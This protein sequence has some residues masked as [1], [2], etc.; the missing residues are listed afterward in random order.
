MRPRPS[1]SCLWSASVAIS[2][3]CADGGT[4]VTGGPWE[5]D[6]VRVSARCTAPAFKVLYARWFKA[7][8]RVRVTIKVSGRL[9][10]RVRLWIETLKLVL[11]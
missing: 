7:R 10:A 4:R 2:R 9:G 1:T 11:A 5:C 6:K 3:T 8:L